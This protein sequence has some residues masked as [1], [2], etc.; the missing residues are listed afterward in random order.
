MTANVCEDTGRTMIPPPAFRALLAMLVMIV[1]VLLHGAFRP[2]LSVRIEMMSTTSAGGELFFA[3]GDNGYSQERSQAFSIVSD[4]QWHRYSVVVPSG[5]RVDRIRIDPGTGTGEVSVRSVELVYGGTRQQL[6]GASLISSLGIT[7]HLQSTALGSDRLSFRSEGVDPYL[8]LKLPRTIGGASLPSRIGKLVLT[9]IAAF[10]VW[11]LLEMLVGPLKRTFAPQWFAIR[12]RKL[13]AI[14]S[15]EQVLR[16]TAPMLVTMACLV[17]VAIVYV[18]LRLNQSSI[19]LWETVYPDAEV[20]QMIDLG[21]PK[22]IRSDEWR[23]HTP[24]VLN[25]VLSGNPIRN[26]NV[27]GELSPVFTALP[28]EGVIGLPQAKL[29]GFRLFGVEVGFSWWW[30]Y[31]T[32]VLIA[33]FLWLC[34]LLTRGNLAASILG[35]AW[36]YTSSFTQ[37][38]FSSL[39]PEI[40]IAFALGMIGAIYALLSSGRWHIVAGCL[41]VV[42]ATT[43]LLLHLYPPFIVPL[44]YLGMFILIGYVVQYRAV[45]LPRHRPWFRS[46]ALLG[47]FAVL[48][49]YGLL[50][51]VQASDTIEAMRNTVYPGQRVSGSGGVPL[52]K[53]LYGFFEPLRLG[54]TSFPLPPTNAS[55]AS[56]FVLLAPIALLVV[57]WNA[58]IRRGSALLVA[59]GS[60]CVVA[61]AWVAF[62]IPAPL[63]RL[64]QFAGWSLVTPKRAVLALGIGSILACVMLF[65]RTQ[66][67][68]EPLRSEPVR[69]MSVVAV[70]LAVVAIG[71]G[72]SQV[73]PGFF[74]WKVV[75]IGAIATTFL[76]AGVALGR[77]ALLATGI[78]MYALTTM[79]VNPLVSGI[80]AIW[81][82]P[83]LLAAKRTGG[84]AADRWVVIGDTNFAQG[85]KAHGLD[86]FAG[87][88]FLPDRESIAILD[89]TGTYEKVWNRY[90][91]IEVKSDPAR[92][93]PLF[94]ARR[95]DQYAITISVCGG[96][97]QS[98]GITHIAYTSP[99]P[100]ED[101]ACLA[102]LPAP[103]DSGVRF[104]RFKQARG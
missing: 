45:S 52:A 97:L 17:L 92:T 15:D 78:A 23:V 76:A 85:L 42:Y 29:A 47:A 21:T 7:N 93:R 74:T 16:V 57:P 68:R 14:V 40:M 90:S 12:L 56:S 72:L 89:P 39:L 73:D 20:T 44:A 95:G 48:T 10:G 5:P 94:V 64:M 30:A 41:L 43:N 58:L 36:V 8:E 98:A 100:S 102:E 6:R 9:G 34:L 18:A 51:L 50:F 1:A 69:R 31:K 99:V 33:S 11:L 2:G 19:G 61:M 49:A 37:W 82:K 67:G 25:Q 79:A 80:S 101:L 32:F 91:T 46:A 65:A 59:L 55:E 84:S 96:K 86:V 81:E 63:E 75:A 71:W 77:S 60:F 83:V 24:W 35:S 62:E 66:Q 103:Q 22:R 53:L 28:V 3:A 26:Q 104:F 54:E 27:G 88:Q 13:A 38:W 4:G 70:G 87:S